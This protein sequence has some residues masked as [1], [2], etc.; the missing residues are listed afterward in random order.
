VCK[1]PAG[2]V[3]KLPVACV[4]GTCTAVCPKWTPNMEGE[5]PDWRCYDFATDAD[6]CGGV[7]QY[8][9]PGEK[10]EDAASSRYTCTD[11]KC[12]KTCDAPTKLV[13]VQGT[14]GLC[15]DT[16][17]DPKNCGKD[18]IKCTETDASGLSSCVEGKC[19]SCRNGDQGSWSVDKKQCRFKA[20][21]QCILPRNSREHC[22]ILAALK[23]ALLAPILPLA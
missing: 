11:T 8:C 1:S 22:R 5:Y 23:S 4:E 21:R 10:D 20:S 3:P 19:E 6:N 14:R 7:D 2:V 16:K 17:S 9:G 15:L 18:R 13:K 12:T